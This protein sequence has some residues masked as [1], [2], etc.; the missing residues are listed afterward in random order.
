MHGWKVYTEHALRWQQSH[1]AP[2]MLPNSPGPA[3]TSLLWTFQAY[4]VWGATLPTI[5]HSESHAT[6]AQWDCLEFQNCLSVLYKSDQT[7]NVRLLGITELS[8]SAIQKWSINQSINTQRKETSNQQLINQ[9]VNTQRKET[10]YWPSHQDA[11]QLALLEGQGLAVDGTLT[12]DAKVVAEASGTEC[13]TA[14]CVQWTDQGLQADLAHEILV[15]RLVV[16]VQVCALGLVKLTA[17]RAHC[18]I[19][20]GMGQRHSSQLLSFSPG[21]ARCDFFSQLGFHKHFTQK[22]S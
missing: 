2:P 17:G 19:P 13:V 14:A 15:H 5:S 18:G 3:S 8:V 16:V 11:G 4:Y 10:P 21:S 6:R 20:W 1:M 7:I 9:S 22:T 12:L